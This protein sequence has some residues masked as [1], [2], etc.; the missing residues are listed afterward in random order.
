MSAADKKPILVTGS[1]RSG[2]TW[3]GNMLALSPEIAYIHEPFN[4]FHRRGVCRASFDVW[5]PYI[6]RENEARYLADIADC[7][8]Y[9]YDLGEGFR[10]APNLRERLIVPRDYARSWLYRVL[11]KRALV[12]DPIAVFSAE[13]LAERFNMEIVA[14]TRHPAAFAGSIKDANWHYPFT[15]FLQQPLLMEQHL[16]AYRAE[17]EKYAQGGQSLVSQA[18][19]L[20]NLIH[21][22]ILYYRKNHPDW[23]FIRHE[24][25]STNP[26]E[27]YHSLYTRLGLDFS[28]RIQREIGRFSQGE[29]HR[30]GYKAINRDSK[31]NVFRWRSRL[32]TDEIRQVRENTA[33]IASAFYTDADWGE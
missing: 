15:H 32:S 14:I 24:D 7:L 9:K 27:A 2:S 22:M 30:R 8:H 4:L 5:F 20:W 1:H 18:I 28:P 23:V 11:Q 12:K 10:S 3:I 25:V 19:L 31:E 29:S 26:L 17:I 33:P 13:W 6:C 21:Q 16:S